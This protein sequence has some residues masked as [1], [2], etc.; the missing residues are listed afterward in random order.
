MYNTVVAID[1][2]TTGP[3]PFK[4]QIIE[5]GAAV[6]Q[7]G[8]ITATFSELA[9]A[10]APMT[11]QIIKL[12]GINPAMLEGCPPLKEVMGRFLEFL[13]K[14][15]LCIA[16]NATFERTFLQRSSDNR[17]TEMILDT[18][19]LS[20]ICFPELESHSL[21][22]LA[23]FLDIVP[24]NAHRALSDCETLLK[25]WQALLDQSIKIPLPVIGEINYLLASQEKHPFRE[26]FRRLEAEVIAR[27]FGKQHPPR[28][29]DV[30]TEDDIRP[31]QQEELSDKEDWIKL[32]RSKVEWVFQEGGFLEK[33]FD[34]FEP[35]P[36]QV[37]MAGEVV[38]AF[39]NGR[40]LLV[41]AGTGTGKSL[42]YLVPAV[43]WA[44][45]NR[46]P[47]IVS[48]NTKN[49]Q[50]QLYDKDIP[51][52]KKAL[53][54]DFNAAIIKGRSNYLCLRKMLYVLRQAD[55]ELDQEER[56]Q[57]VTLLT[58]AA[59]TESGD[60]SE[61][62]VT[63]RPG[64]WALW[65]KLSTTGDDCLGRGCKQYSRCFLR[66]ARSKALAA[67]IVIANHSLVF[68]ELNTK[69]PN[70][71][72]YAQ[73][74]FDEAHNLEDAAT[75]HLSIQISSSRLDIILNRLL[76]HGRKKNQTGLIPSII[77]KVN[78]ARTLGAELHALLMR[79]AQA[80]PALVAEV[81]VPAEAFFAE[82]DV[83]RKAGGDAPNL[84][85][86]PERRLEQVWEPVEEA[87]KNLCISL[88]ALMHESDH[89]LAALKDVPPDTVEY[90]REFIRDLDSAISWIKEFTE[91]LEFVLAAVNNDYVYWI[92][93]VNS[94]AG[95]VSL[96]AAPVSVGALLHDQLYA[97]KRSII[98]CSA[99]LSVRGSFDFVKKRLGVDRIDTARL[100]QFDAGSPFD[101]AKQC[102]VLVPGFLPEPG[103]RGKDYTTELANLMAEVFRV[104]RGR[105]LGLFTSYDMLRRSFEIL[106]D[107]LL[108]DGIEILAQ[109]HSGSRNNITAVFKRGESSV[110]LGT[111]SFWEGVDVVGDALSCLVIARL[112]F[113]VFTDPVV[114]ARCE[115][116]EAE[117]G[118]AFMCYSLPSAVIRFKQGF[119]RLIRH[120]NDRG[121]VIIADRRI[122][123]KKYG[124]WFEDSLPC[125]TKVCNDHESFLD[126]IA[127][128]LK[129]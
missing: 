57:V 88:A 112:P 93:R 50:A 75:R 15:A 105:A 20:R 54:I 77:E 31:P 63:G 60:I 51:F 7:G 67:Q 120:K 28:F 121:V 44:R 113:A 41:E 117:G 123:A 24:E 3:D 86:S 74:V 42:A 36:G 98:F 92:E 71:P 84:R 43:I 68:A 85:Y 35:R 128:F 9:A 108:G 14:D 103:E 55:A 25:L 106:S 27:D 30:F 16:H 95:G 21:A 66:K 100:T 89:L 46:T 40:H 104:T 49:L 10:T 94:R 96:I 109:G 97:K 110:L 69:N 125:K 23:D 87:K 127:H 5:I 101:Y 91:E 102:R 53:G 56:M 90:A 80:I 76:R 34:N 18:V 37:Q 65:A 17:F 61:N 22:C 82:L 122:V 8:K 126:D 116:V 124:R 32:D 6:Y 29:E 73:I 99:T 64:F 129:P 13:P 12:T 72:Q 1:L 119:G 38:E 115:R 52:V 33:S 4:D 26:Y 79:H 114:E 118:N 2:E 58:W 19:G 83:I 78:A 47:V 39:N 59:F 62:I 48:T 111:H 11:S 70:L 81:G 107:E 45:E